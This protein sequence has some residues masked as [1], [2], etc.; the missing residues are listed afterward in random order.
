MAPGRVPL[1]AQVESYRQISARPDRIDIRLTVGPG[2]SRSC[3]GCEAGGY[4][5]RVMREQV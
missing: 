2:G 1:P 3:A 4:V 5:E